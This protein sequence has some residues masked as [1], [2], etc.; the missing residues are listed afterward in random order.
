MNS[1]KV[2]DVKGMSCPM[3]ILRTK[4]EMDT[5]SSG[6]ILEIHVTDQGALADMPA[7]ANAA[8]HTILDKKTEADVITF[9]IQKG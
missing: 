7:W 4:K 3:P 6:D 1:T 5:L 8:G 2:L 9:F